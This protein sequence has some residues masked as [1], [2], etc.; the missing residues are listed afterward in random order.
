MSRSIAS[1]SQDRRHA[2]VIVSKYRSVLLD[3]D[4]TLS[5]IEGIDWLAARRG[6]EIARAVSVLTAQAMTGE[7]LLNDVYAARLELVR[8]T[9]EE[10]ALLAEAYWENTAPGAAAA[11]ERLK[12]ESVRLVV[13]TSGIHD[14]VEPFVAR[15]GMGAEDVHAVHLEFDKNGRYRTFDRSAPLVVFGGKRIVAESL[16]L[17]RPIL[18]VGDGITDA[19]IRPAADAFAAFT[20]FVRR[21]AIVAIADFVVGSFADV[22]RLV[23]DGEE[24][25]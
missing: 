8:P 20:G 6:S 14:A 5:G 7:R 15:L 1:Q 3:V 25:A 13:V 16:A 9:V 10:V 4:S 22:E 24:S 17:E 11:I 2:D 19:E 12:S 21:D 23:L 18:A